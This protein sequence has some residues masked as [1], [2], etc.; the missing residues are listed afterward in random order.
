MYH[1]VHSIDTVL[2]FYC[3]AADRLVQSWINDV[4]LEST[5]LKAPPTSS[6]FL[7]SVDWLHGDVGQSAKGIIQDLM[8][9]DLDVRTKKMVKKSHNPTVSMEM[10]HKK[11]R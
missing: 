9:K 2:L 11:V 1:D 3:S 4:R 8:T 6:D 7:S 5:T 10:R